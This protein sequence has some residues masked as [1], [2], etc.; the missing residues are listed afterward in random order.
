MSDMDDA[1]LEL[2]DQAENLL[3]TH[4]DLN[5]KDE[6]GRP[7]WHTLFNW[8]CIEEACKFLQAGARVDI[9]GV[10]WKTYLM[11]ACENGSLDLVQILLRFGADV[12][13]CSAYQQTPI[14]LACKGTWLKSEDG[15]IKEI[16]EERTQC[17]KLLISRGAD[18]NVRTTQ[19]DSLLHLAAMTA[20][21]D[22]ITELVN[23]GLDPNDVRRSD[24]AT[25]LSIASE[26]DR[27]DIA[28]ELLRMGA[29]PNKRV[30]NGATA[31]IYATQEGHEK[32]AR[33]LLGH[34]ADPYKRRNGSD[35]STAWVLAAQFGQTGCLKAMHDHGVPIDHPDDE[36]FT[37]LM[38]AAQDGHEKCVRELLRLGA[39]PFASNR[40]GG[41]A[42]LLARQ[43]N[44]SSVIRMLEQAMSNW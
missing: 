36:G 31:L 33:V 16:S 13:H 28:A 3:A 26:G 24:F 4:G 1:I 18:V 22:A 6:Y 40:R 14:L 20:T 19:G 43:E 15:L 8:G 9:P 44:H 42:Y 12:N 17:I 35:G 32:T 5:T 11:S 38:F 21:V 2:K 34:G 7:I 23:A 29:D 39:N 30:L 25:P 27:A 37:A 41:N 10:D